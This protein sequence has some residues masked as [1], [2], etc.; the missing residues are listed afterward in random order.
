MIKALKK[1]FKL[2]LHSSKEDILFEKKV[3]DLTQ[4]MQS[5][6]EA[7]DSDACRRQ[8]ADYR[9]LEHTHLG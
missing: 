6:Q 1:W 4:R 7:V 3:N 5:I 2:G 9:F 8:Q